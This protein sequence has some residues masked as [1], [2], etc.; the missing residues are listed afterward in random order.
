[1]AYGTESIKSVDFIC[2]PGNIWVTAAKKEV[3]G[4]VGI[5]GIY[6]PTETMVIVDETSNY[7][8][9]ASDLLAQSEHDTAATPMLISI[10]SSPGDK[11]IE[12]LYQQLETIPRKNIAEISIRNRGVCFFC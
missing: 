6:G 12:V 8:L 7:N 9:A 2:G 10:G 11:I 4:K 5:D 1:M 3:F